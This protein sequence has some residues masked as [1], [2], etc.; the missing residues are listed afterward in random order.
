M[1]HVRCLDSTLFVRCDFGVFA[2]WQA[3]PTDRSSEEGGRSGAGRYN[4]C[5]AVSAVKAKD[6]TAS[7][8]NLFTGLDVLA[9]RDDGTGQRRSA[10]AN[11]T[12]AVNLTLD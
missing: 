10:S 3:R 4:S 2:A 8:N 5:F 6:V 11:Q 12:A 9:S 7:I 1:H